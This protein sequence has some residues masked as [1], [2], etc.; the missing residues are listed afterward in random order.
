MI[1]HK[2]T[3]NTAAVMIQLS[4]LLLDTQSQKH[5]FKG[6]VS[7]FWLW[8]KWC[9]FTKPTV[10]HSNNKFLWWVALPFKMSE[11]CTVL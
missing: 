11:T 10:E 7:D 5:K 6:F 4:I 3:T 1:D 8:K 9:I 2:M